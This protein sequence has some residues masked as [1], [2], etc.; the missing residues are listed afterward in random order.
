[1]V[2]FPKIAGRFPGQ[3]RHEEF[4][5]GSYCGVVE[6]SRAIECITPCLLVNSS[7]PF[8]LWYCRHLQG[9]A[10]QELILIDPE[11]SN[12]ICIMTQRNVREDFFLQQHFYANIRY[13]YVTYIC[14]FIRGRTDSNTADL[15]SCYSYRHDIQMAARQHIATPFCKWPTAS[16]RAGTAEQLQWTGGESR[17]SQTEGSLPR[18]QNITI[19]FYRRS[20]DKR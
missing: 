20:H 19:G 7:R 6:Y 2:R 13:V 15:E 14:A 11:T 8:E 1:M 12:I 5:L 10:I 4:L 9:E 18:S 3:Q 17:N 16:F